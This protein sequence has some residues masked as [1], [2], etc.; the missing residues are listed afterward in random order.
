MATPSSSSSSLDLSPP[1]ASVD[2]FAEF[3]SQEPEWYTLG[4]FLGAPEE[5]LVRI[6]QIR[7]ARVITSYIEMYTVLRSRR[8]PLSWDYIATALKRIH[9]QDLADKI[10]EIYILPHLQRLSSESKKEDY[11]PDGNNPSSSSSPVDTTVSIVKPTNS[12]DAIGSDEQSAETVK[13]I[14]SEYTTLS[15]KFT[16][17]KSRV[18]SAFK[19]SPKY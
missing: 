10:H 1:V 6:R 11:K 14:T 17:I 18:K 7:T 16:I 12:S 15:E 9:R 4:V 19:T 3:L 13:A 2:E 8:N 5:E